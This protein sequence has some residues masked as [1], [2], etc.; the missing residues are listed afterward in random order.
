MDDDSNTSKST[1]EDLLTVEDLHLL[2]DLFYLPYEHGSQG[3]QLL[4]EFQW[5]KTNASAIVGISNKDKT[6]P[7]V[8]VIYFTDPHI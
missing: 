6:K 3:L 5:L 8:R 2:C 7:E 1:E 4:N